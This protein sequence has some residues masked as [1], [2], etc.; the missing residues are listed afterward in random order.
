MDAAVAARQHRHAPTL[1]GGLG[2]QQASLGPGAHS[3]V[4]RAAGGGGGLGGGAGGQA[5]DERG[6][7]HIEY[8]SVE[9]HGLMYHAPTFLAVMLL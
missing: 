6:S 5:N 7:S 4:G 2:C 9:V 8:I 1:Q 3:Q